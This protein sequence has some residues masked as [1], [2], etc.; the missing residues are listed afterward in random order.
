M[1]KK[2]DFLHGSKSDDPPKPRTP[3]EHPNTLKSRA[4][5]RFIEYICEGEI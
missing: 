2:I 1:N 5:S 4:I 3:I